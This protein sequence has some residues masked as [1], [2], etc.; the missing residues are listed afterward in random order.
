MQLPQFPDKRWSR[1]S[2][3]DEKLKCSTACLCALFVPVFYGRSAFAW[4]FLMR[5]SEVDDLNW[6]KIKHKKVEEVFFFQHGCGCGRP[7]CLYLSRDTDTRSPIRLSMTEGHRSALHK[8]GFSDS[9]WKEPVSPAEY[10]STR[11]TAVMHMV[12]CGKEMRRKWEYLG[13]LNTAPH[14]PHALVPVLSIGLFWISYPCCTVDKIR[15][16]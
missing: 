16:V 1:S 2:A 5:L 7:F 11:A 6:N 12:C 13:S 14:P 8:A 4:R 15:K 9:C 10:R 3:K